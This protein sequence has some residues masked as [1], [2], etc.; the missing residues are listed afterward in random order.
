MKH[1]MKD[2]MSSRTRFKCLGPG[3]TRAPRSV[4]FLASLAATAGVL[5]LVLTVYAAGMQMD[6]QDQAL[7]QAHLVDVVA[8]E[9]GRQAALQDLP[10]R[11]AA[12]YA[13]GLRDGVASMEGTTE[14][15]QLAQACAAWR[16]LP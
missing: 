12:A 8:F 11:L 5:A 6:L 2:D 14:G 4:Q 16:A 15:L 10:V 9:Q 7:Q 3:T 1:D 13:A